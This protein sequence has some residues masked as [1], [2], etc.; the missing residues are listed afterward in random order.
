MWSTEEIP[1]DKPRVWVDI[2]CRALPVLQFL[3]KN[4][5]TVYQHAK[6]ENYILKMKL[7]GKDRNQILAQ[8]ILGFL[9]INQKWTYVDDIE[10]YYQCSGLVADTKSNIYINQ[11][12]EIS[13]CWID[14]LSGRT[15]GA[16][17]DLVNTYASAILGNV[18]DD[19]A[20]IICC[21]C[22]L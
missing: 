12:I 21:V 17:G 2:W 13:Q 8:R 10:K 9:N 20:K 19:L 18:L 7:R 15:V 1:Y 14:K 5:K 16:S 4:V 6:S 3:S 22:Y 11:L